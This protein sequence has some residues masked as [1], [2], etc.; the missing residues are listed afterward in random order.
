[1]SLALTT[2]ARPACE[3]PPFLR[4]AGKMLAVHEAPRREGEIPPDCGIRIG[5]APP[6]WPRIL[7]ATRPCGSLLS[8]RQW[9][10][11]ARLAPRRATGLMILV[12]LLLPACSDGGAASDSGAPAAPPHPGEMVYEQFCFSCHAAGIAGAPTTGDVEAWAARAAKG[13]EALLQ[14]TLAGIPPGMPAKGLCL[15]C[16]EA[17]LNAAIDYMM[18]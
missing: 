13:R 15:D 3:S 8:V 2:Q 17:E 7:S 18:P 4:L 12:C 9:M 11:F 16:S 1:M 5:Q 14:T 10:G 6:L